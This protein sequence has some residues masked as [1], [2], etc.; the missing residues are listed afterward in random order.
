VEVELEAGLG[1]H[2]PVYQDLHQAILN[3][4]PLMVDGVEGRK[5]LEL[6][7]AMLYSDL[8]REEV[9]LPLDRSRYASMI[10]EL[11]TAKKMT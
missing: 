3:G 5:S 11:R 4:S 6:A 7:N 8:M 2:L 9:S 10:E 1:G